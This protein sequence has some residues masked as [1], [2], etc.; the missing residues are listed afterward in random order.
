MI[1]VRHER[2]HG[3]FEETHKKVK[4]A[5]KRGY[6]L[7]DLFDMKELDEVLGDTLKPKGTIKYGKAMKGLYC[8]LDLRGTRQEAVDSLL[9]MLATYSE[10]VFPIETII[11]A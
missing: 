6:T 4:E 7:G 2:V 9:A 1:V 8:E 10:R 5:L 3:N 11:F